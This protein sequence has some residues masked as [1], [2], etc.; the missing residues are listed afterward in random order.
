MLTRALAICLCTT[1]AVAAEVGGVASYPARPIRLIIGQAPGG[2]LDI[3]ARALAQKMGESFG[4]SVVADNRP[5]PRARWT[6][7]WLPKPRPMVT[8]C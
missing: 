7:P 8:R 5:V 2:G 4:Q 1:A 3:T 6:W